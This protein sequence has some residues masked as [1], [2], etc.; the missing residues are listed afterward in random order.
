M[1]N[2]RDAL[3][4]RVTVPPETE[5]V[6]LE[7]VKLQLRIDS[8]DTSFDDQIKALIPAARA[9]CEGYQNRA[10]IT[11]TIELALD[12]WPRGDEIRLPRPPLQAVS[13]VTYTPR[14][15]PVSTVSTSSYIVDA[16]SEPGYLVTRDRWPSDCLD[17][18]NAIKV[19]YTAGYGNAPDDVPIKIRQ[20][21]IMLTCFWFE[22]GMCDP[23]AAVESLLDQERVM[24]V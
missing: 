11:Q 7:A 8:D 22:N 21:I 1:R 14:S 2:G 13:A 17:V 16:F 23:P 19:T 20:A 10:Y 6:T 4:Y 24:P 18:A 15:G 9:E 5:P 3:K 12:E